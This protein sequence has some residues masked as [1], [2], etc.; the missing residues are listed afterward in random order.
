MHC[1]RNLVD[2]KTGREVWSVK[3]GGTIYTVPLVVGDMVYVGS[4]DKSLYVLDLKRREI[5]TKMQGNSKIFC[6]PASINGYVYFGS[7]D[8]SIYRINPKTVSI[9]GKH[10]L[11]D[12]I[13][14]KI[15]YSS[16]NNL[17]YALTYTNQLFA[18]RSM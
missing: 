11:P 2:L 14:N 10:Q 6:P 5:H 15:A 18:L 8:G 16:R 1:H 3:T 12:A 4:T 13:T 9:D 7:C 17:Y